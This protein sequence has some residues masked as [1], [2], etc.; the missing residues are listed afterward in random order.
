MARGVVYDELDESSCDS[1][2]V[3][4]EHGHPTWKMLPVKEEEEE[5]MVPSLSLSVSVSLSALSLI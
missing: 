1:Q 5:E 3:P 2:L 4:N